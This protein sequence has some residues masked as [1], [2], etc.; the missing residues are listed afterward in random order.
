MHRIE[1]F[2]HVNHTYLL[3]KARRRNFRLAER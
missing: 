1:G 2:H 3:K